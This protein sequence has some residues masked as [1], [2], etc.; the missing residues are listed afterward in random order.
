LSMG[1]ATI[2]RELFETVQKMDDPV[3]RIVELNDYLSEQINRVK[4]MGD[5]TD[6]EFGALLVRDSKRIK[7]DFIVVGEDRSIEL[8]PKRKLDPDEYILGTIHLHPITN[9]PSVHDMGSFLK[10]PWEQV[11]MLIGSEGTIWLLRKTPETIVPN[12]DLT[13]WKQMV[14]EQDYNMEQLAEVYHFEVF[15]GSQEKL[16]SVYPTGR[17]E[18]TVDQLLQD[19]RGIKDV[20]QI[21]SV[22][23]SPFRDHPT[24]GNGWLTYPTAIPNQKWKREI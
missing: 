6:K 2:W 23:K 3:P 20:N 16:K 11:M 8:D 1:S 5:V 18:A 24:E 21:D 9:R 10:S 13:T 15:N 22:K 14:G 12:E 7:L 17:G 19:I 4:K